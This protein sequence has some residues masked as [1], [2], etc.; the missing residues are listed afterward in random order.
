MGTVFSFD[1]RGGGTEAVRTALDEAVASLHAV[2]A[3]F[4]TYR[5]DSQVSRLARGELTVGE[6]DPQVAEVLELCAEAQRLSGGWFSATY[7]GSLDPTGIVKGWATERAMLR[8]AAAGASGVSVNGGGDVQLYGV[9]GPERPWRVGVSDPLRPGA[10]AAV[11]SAAGTERL[12][13]ATSGT[14]ERGAHVV[15]P[16]TGRSAVTDLVAVTVVAPRLTWADAWATAAFAMGSRQALRWLESLP[17]TEAL[18]I[19]GGNEVR[20]T[21]GLADRLG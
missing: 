16:R 19:T 6:C 12:S 14:A 4:S 9:P 5:E 11:V 1:V 18:L 21:G 13:V 10:L 15:D 3:V 2:D 17:E 8:L 20:C 7:E